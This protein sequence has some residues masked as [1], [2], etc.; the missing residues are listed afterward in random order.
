MTSA[1][2]A[3][4]VLVLSSTLGCSSEPADLGNDKTGENLG[5]YAGSW[6]G[7]AEAYEFGG[8][9]DRVRVV[10]DA[11]GVGTIEFGD[12]PAVPA[13]D[14]DIGYMVD[15]RTSFILQGQDLNAVRVGFPY[16]VRSSTVEVKRLRLGIDPRELYQAWCQLQTSYLDEAMDRYTCLPE[17]SGIGPLQCPA[18]ALETECC[19]TR[20]SGLS[21]REDCGKMA[22]CSTA[23]C[24][25]TAAGCDIVMETGAPVSSYHTRLDA[26]LQAGATELVGTLALDDE[27][28]VNVRLAR[29]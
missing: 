27:T 16:A 3:V 1:T 2:R 21:V 18:P 15:H 24:D 19:G 29:Q 28:S 17:A 10:L 22:L 26:A 20:A 14:P 25:C 5:D 23:V 8:V 13:P 12:G 4:T 6:A 11:S 9:S 7:Y